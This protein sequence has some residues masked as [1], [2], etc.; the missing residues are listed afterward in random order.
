MR[1]R[2][3]GDLSASESP[4]SQP[5]ASHAV[6]EPDSKPGSLS[7]YQIGRDAQIATAI[8]DRTAPNRP[9]ERSRLLV[10]SSAARLSLLGRLPPY[11]FEKLGKPSEFLR[12]ER[13]H[14]VDKTVIS[15]QELVFIATFGTTT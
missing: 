3:L 14:K 8:L 11:S 5:N 4:G 9:V 7:G 6:D 2:S 12:T 13:C 15:W 1:E 10:G